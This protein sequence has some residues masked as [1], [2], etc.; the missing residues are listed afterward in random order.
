MATDRP[1]LYTY[2]RCPYA[3][4]AR[5]ALLIAG[6]PF[7]AHEIE[8]RHK[9][10][11]LLAASPKGTVPVL[12]LP[13]GRVLEQS[14]DIVEWALTQP[15]AKGD[16]H[17]WWLNACTPDLQALLQRNDSDFKHHLDRYKYP[18]RH[19]QVSPEDKPAVQQAHRQQALDVFLVPLEAR[20]RDVPFVGG[21]TPC[22]IDIGIFPF[23]RQFA[24]VDAVWFEGLPLPR[25]RAWLQGWTGSALFD[26]CMRKL[27]A[28]VP[29]AFEPSTLP[30]AHVTATQ[31]P[32]QAA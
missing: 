25:V 20:L 1:L 14:W 3:M 9:P 28:N 18:E 11:A 30:L 12:V 2:R 19:G 32:T 10:P 23:V 4:R 17:D 7:D 22:A 26:A 21:Q 16:A 5:M 29:M 27:V 31:A 8:L 24:A 15:D 13:D 6:V